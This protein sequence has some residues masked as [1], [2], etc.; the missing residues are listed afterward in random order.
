MSTGLTLFTGNRLEILAQ[1]L[2]KVLEAPMGNPLTPDTVVLQSQGM[3]R[4]LSLALSC[5]NGICANVRWRFPNAFVQEIFQKT[6]PDLSEARRFDAK[7]TAWKILSELSELENDPAF[8]SLAAYLGRD[9]DPLKRYQISELFADTLDQYLTYRPE[10]IESWDRGEGHDFQAI[11]YRR[12]QASLGYRHRVHLMQEFKTHFQGIDINSKNIP[13][14]INVFGISSLPEF[15]MELFTTLAEACQVNL[16][17]L[18]P[19]PDF[20]GEIRSEAETRR[21]MRKRGEE[22][23]TELLSTDEL[24]LQTGNPLLASMGGQGREFF[25]MVAERGLSDFPLFVEP[26]ETTLL[27][28][29]QSDIYHMRDRSKEGAP[30]EVLGDD[31]S[32]TVHSCHSATREVE[33]LRD[34]V[35]SL[36]ANDDNLLPSDFVVMAP[37]IS[38]YAPIIEAVFGRK[39]EAGKGRLPFSIADQAG[40]ATNR[41]V[42]AFLLLLDLSGFRFEASRV[43][44]LLENQR[45]R[46]AFDIGQAHL[47]TIERWLEDAAIRWG[48]DASRREKEGFQP[49]AQNSWKEGLGRL[50]MGYAAGEDHGLW[51]GLLP[52][53]PVEGEGGALLGHLARFIA[54]LSRYVEGLEKPKPAD[55]WVLFFE[56]IL[57]D[58]LDASGSEE[59]VQAVRHALH[60]MGDAAKGAE[61]ESAVPFE[62]VRFILKTALGE[63]DPVSGFITGGITF[64]S[65]LPMRSIPFK[66]VALLGMGHGAFPRQH[67]AP[68]FDLIAKHP[69]RGDRSRRRDD[70]YLFLEIILSVRETLWISY[71][72]Q[73]IRDNT[74]LQPSVLLSELL[75]YVDAS[76]GSAETSK[77]L[78]VKHPLHPFSLAYFTETPGLFTYDERAEK[79]AKGL[80]QPPQLQAPFLSTGDTLEGEAHISTQEL[81]S[82][83]ANPFKHRMV[84]GLG[85]SLMASTEPLDDEEPFAL[86]GLERHRTGS[87]LFENLAQ[88]RPLD[89]A[90]LEVSAMGILPRGVLGQQHLESASQSAREITEAMAPYTEATPMRKTGRVVVNGQPLTYDAGPLFEDVL[91]FGRFGRVRPADLLAVWV[92][93]LALAQGGEAIGSA[94]VAGLDKEGKGQALRLAVPPNAGEILNQLMALYR[95]GMAGYLP[96]FPRASYEWAEAFAPKKD[97]DKAMTKAHSA[98]YGGYQG[99]CDLDDPYVRLGLRG[100]EP[101]SASDQPLFTEIAQAVYSPILEAMIPC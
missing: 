2:A 87:L 65:M 99:I 17:L 30:M 15:H 46:S 47:E 1:G 98:L 96:L 85:L 78:V 34:W 63:P 44:G 83:L 41:A 50:F 37:D 68:G 72:G 91:L 13:E 90:S 56:E 3:S 43:M 73:S 66:V 79:V 67:R 11:L 45:I 93:L 49:F 27:G 75:D 94:V 82:F 77:K 22:T 74:T 36:M 25:D 71:T 8:S 5:H 80:V 60:R 32:L 48:E 95:E 38:T 51:D 31:T 88:G 55:A 9:A 10:M 69:K 28:S 19:C 23:E 40:G 14:R 53:G 33:V 26:D 62:V 20:W 92:P 24:M 84:R 7:V 86:G 81:A 57:G 61:N 76:T 12:L 6:I 16:F 89:H 101:L 39:I 97:A 21:L 18:N 58:F 52:A 29:I 35:I 54:R 70:R 42:E 64:C 4:W 100:H 59:D